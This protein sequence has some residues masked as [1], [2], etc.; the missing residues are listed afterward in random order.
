MNIFLVI[1]VFTIYLIR[2]ILRIIQN[3]LN[4]IYR[5]TNRSILLFYTSGHLA[6]T[7]FENIFFRKTYLWI[8]LSRCPFNHEEVSWGFQ[9]TKN[10]RWR[11]AIVNV[12]FPNDDA[13]TFQ[14]NIE[15]FFI[16][17]LLKISF[18]FTILKS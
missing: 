1:I 3:M 2:L 9:L 17:I 14:C 6:K 11:L 4:W 5:Y 18:F 16:G 13:L 15:L 8:S 12:N 7:D 10:I